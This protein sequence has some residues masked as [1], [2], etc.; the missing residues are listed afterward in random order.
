MTS[1][2]KKIMMVAGCAVH[3]FCV[4]LSPANAEILDVIFDWKSTFAAKDSTQVNLPTAS[5]YFLLGVFN[6][7]PTNWSTINRANLSNSFTELDREAYLGSGSIRQYAFNFETT[8]ASS[9]PVAQVQAFL[10]VLSGS[11]ELGV[12][13]WEKNG[14][15]FYLPRVDNFSDAYAVSTNFGKAGSYNM[16]SF[17]GSVSATGIQ[18]TAAAGAVIAPQSITFNSISSKSVGD[19]F[20]LD[21]SATSGLPVAYTSSNPSV[22]TVAGNLVTIVGSGS[23]EITAS[24]AGNSSFSAATSQ[25][26][27]LTAYGSTAL[28][29]ASLGIPVLNAGQT[30]VTH[31]FVGNPNATY[32]IE[33]K[34]DLSASIWST[35][36]AQTDANGSFSATF[37]SSGDYV[38]AWKSRMFFRAKNS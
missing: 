19:S 22:A 23:A 20:T 25:V 35:L 2:H 27:Q 37:T 15:P 13:G 32:T 6:T 29:L 14:T 38:N 7:V 18:T 31:T 12:F 9:D 34:T 5:T 16:T 36:T 4:G 17:V 26:R 21:A 10:V 3:M 30:T 24:Q 11:S 28:R 33:Y 1:Q 8:L